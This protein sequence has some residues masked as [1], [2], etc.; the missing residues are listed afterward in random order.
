MSQQSTAISDFEKPASGGSKTI[1]EFCRDH[2]ISRSFFYK[3]RALGIGPDE[4]HV[5]SCVRVTFEAEKRWQQRGEQR[6]R[7]L[8]AV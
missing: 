5:N 4:L 3:M 6:A 7:E 2:R 8:T 1:S